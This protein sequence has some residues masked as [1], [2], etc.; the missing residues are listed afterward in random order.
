[1]A[2]LEFSPGVLVAWQIG[3]GEA[4]AAASDL[5]EKD[6]VFIG[7]CKVDEA[8]ANRNVEKLLREESERLTAIFEA[9]RVDR[10][11]LRRRIRE[12][13]SKGDPD[14]TLPEPQDMHRSNACRRA[15]DLAADLALKSKSPVIHSLHL[16]SAVLQNPGPRIAQ[17]ITSSGADFDRFREAILRAATD[18][19]PEAGPA[20]QQTD[21]AIPVPQRGLLA[22]YGA[23]LTALAK[24]GKIEPLIGR[25]N[26]L[27]SLM[28]TLT[29]KTKNNPIV[30][31]DPGVGKT[32]IV[33]GLAQRIAD[34]SVV[35]DLKDK[36]IIELNM[37][38]L[39]AG[40]KYRGEFEERLTGLVE[41][42]KKRPEVILFID[43][44]HTM[45]GAGS[46]QGSLDA[47]NIL[48]PVLSGGEIRCIGSTTT[49]EY[50]KYFEKDAALA[51]R[52][53]P[54]MVGEP[55]AED[56]LNILQG[57]RERYEQHHKVRIAPD[58]LPATIDLS[59]RHLP[60]RRLPD[61]ALDLLDESCTRVKINTI[62]FKVGAPEPPL[63]TPL[64]V[65]QVLSEW[66]GIPAGKLTSDRQ[67]R[68]R[69]IEAALS[70]RVIGQQEAV[71]KVS[72]IMI[73]AHAGLRDPNRPL[74]VFLFLGPTGV[75]KTEL[76]KALAEFLFGSEKEMIRLDM[77]EY[78]EKHTVSRMIGAPPGYIGHDE[79]GQLTGAL[80]RRPYSVVLLDEI[81]KAHP[82]VLDVFLQL[83]DEG[84]MTDS[85][86]R[87]VDGKNAV[88]IMTS[89][90]IAGLAAPP[91]GLGFLSAT[92]V[93]P[94]AAFDP[95]QA[96]AGELLK[97]FR[98][99]FL[100]R[101]DE[102]QLFSPL[103]R[104]QLA[105][106]AAKL[107]DALVH[108]ASQQNIDLH[109]GQEL[110]DFIVENGYDPANGARP[111]ARA[112]DRLIGRPLGEAIVG[113]DIQPGDNV[114]IQLDGGQ[115]AFHSEKT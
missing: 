100:N 108:R 67:R 25:R 24:E 66:T 40:T 14:A 101:I 37:G 97:H 84:R 53:Q 6:H 95:R 75:G 34:G 105:A 85:Q 109:Y 5:I 102:I 62:S 87:T 26:E 79:E 18:Y 42:A 76:S 54:V 71:K 22:R 49:A 41:E 69:Q 29:R 113:G 99:E 70:R 74:G 43:E 78:M 98:P 2:F 114:S 57:L 92:G 36:L 16:L 65:A 89:N 19:V 106:I 110:A 20:A 83:F 96:L 7:L 51:R 50:R 64:V 91:R 11:R 48:K 88:Y 39:V 107:L 68:L 33:R 1:M 9:S 94:Q 10:A 23:D 90:A 21:P 63:V 45:V 46:A 12:L 47:A 72:E 111:L 31:G 59:V 27:L 55:S 30:I 3:A 56:T 61:K 60:D 44:I 38:I 104:P 93:S 73:Q 35:A 82:Q 103:E 17:A 112:V 52:F 115:V 80:R 86:G 32:A 4:L 28:R 15:F 13:L 8:V 77:S 58:C 81:E